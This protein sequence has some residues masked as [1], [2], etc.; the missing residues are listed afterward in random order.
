[1][2]DTGKTATGNELHVALAFDAAYVLP[3]Y[4]TMRSV[5]LSTRRRA[6]LMFHLCHPGLDS[7][8][9]EDLAR[10]HSEFGARLRHHDL[11]ADEGYQHLATTLPHTRHISAVMYA[12]MLLGRL[13]DDVGGRVAY[14]DCD[15]LVR[16]PIEELLAH[17]LEGKP[18]GAVREPHSLRF[19]HGRDARHDFDLLDPADPYFNSGVLVIDLEAWR[20]M[21]MEKTLGELERSGVLARLP[22][23]QQILNVIFANNWARIGGE[24][25]MFAASKAI[26]GLDPKIVHYTGLNKPWNLI[27]GLPFS[28]VYRHVMTNEFFYRY[29]RLRWKRKIF[30]L[31][32]MQK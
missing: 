27:N 19:A 4:A 21:D 32:G 10:I 9:R 8:A 2:A 14:L 24:W 30:G 28:R 7:S 16:A 13:L 3:A 25:N 22:N 11:S 20:D 12:R 29:F 15:V 17:D 31:L 23:D 1:M 18:L 6:D 26:E 5:C